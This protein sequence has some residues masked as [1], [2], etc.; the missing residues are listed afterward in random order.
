MEKCD[1]AVLD[2]ESHV[3][4]D[5]AALGNVILGTTRVIELARVGKVSG[6][7][8]GVRQFDCLL[9]FDQTPFNV[10]KF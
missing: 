4:L 10:N 7:E 6:S 5:S 2:T 8:A 9:R 1:R 3:A